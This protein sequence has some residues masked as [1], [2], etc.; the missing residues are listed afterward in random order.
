MEGKSSSMQEDA[1]KARRASTKTGKN[2]LITVQKG[3]K[4]TGNALKWFQRSERGAT[5]SP[6]PFF[7]FLQP[8]PPASD[9]AAAASDSHRN[10]RIF[11]LID[12]AQTL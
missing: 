11:L 7:L 6:A 3:A 4:P 8:L 1:R 5:F 9:L 12:R 10:R 2:V